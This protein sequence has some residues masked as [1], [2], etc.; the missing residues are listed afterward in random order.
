MPENS[1]GM[2]RLYK[3]CCPSGRNTGPLRYNSPRR[4]AVTGVAAPPSEETRKM[5]EVEALGK[6]RRT[7]LVAILANLSEVAVL[8]FTQRRTPRREPC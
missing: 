3:K 2:L 5:G 6:D 4:I 7:H 8:G 1:G